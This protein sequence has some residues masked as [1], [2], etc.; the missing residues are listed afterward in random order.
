MQRLG[1]LWQVYHQIQQEKL[2]V[3]RNR[4][5]RS[6]LQGLYLAAVYPKYHSTVNLILSDSAPKNKLIY[7]IL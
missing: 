3:V 4:G 7:Q 6:V 1:D 2:T 5:G